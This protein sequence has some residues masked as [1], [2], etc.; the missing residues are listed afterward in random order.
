MQTI[1]LKLKCNRDL[2]KNM[3]TSL[4]RQTKQIVLYQLY[5]PQLKDVLTVKLAIGGS[6]NIDCSNSE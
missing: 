3:K 5:K 6:E 4:Q 1:N 2:N